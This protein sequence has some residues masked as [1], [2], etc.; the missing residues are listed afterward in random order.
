MTRRP[1]L[2]L[3]ALAVLAAP[4]AAQPTP[5]KD[6]ADLFPPDTLAYAEVV[7]PAEIARAVSAFAKGTI[8]E[9]MNAFMAKWRDKRGDGYFPDVMMLGTFSA[10]AGPEA[11]AEA[12]RLQGAAVALTN[13]DKKGDPEIV[14]VILPGQSNVPGFIMRM[15]MTVDGSM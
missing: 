7:K 8:I 11:M 10:F 5:V 6:L 15:I 1:L 3:A 2:V 12:A 13:I 9:D 14:G 4:A